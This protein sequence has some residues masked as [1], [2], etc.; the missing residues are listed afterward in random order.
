[1]AVSRWVSLLTSRREGSPDEAPS[2]LGDPTARKERFPLSQDSGAFFHR[3]RSSPLS[4]KG[5]GLGLLLVKGSEMSF[6]ECGIDLLPRQS[7]LFSFLTMFLLS[8]FSSLF[9]F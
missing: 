6:C 8:G 5:F 4:L 9:Q 2:P 1:M 3:L 7:W